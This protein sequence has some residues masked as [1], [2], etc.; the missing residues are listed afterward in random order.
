M[1][2][3]FKEVD[4][5]DPRRRFGNRG[6]D[7][8]AVFLMS[9]GFKIL[10]RNWSCR[11][12]EIDVIAE[13][14]GAVHFVEVKTRRSRMYGNPEDSITRTKLLHLRRTIEVYLQQARS[15]PRNYQA[16]A[17]AITA[18]PGQKPEFYYVEN[19]FG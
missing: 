3:D 5:L 19:I 4:S 11:L 15:A 1:A 14:N 9:R 7:L 8:A 13:K 10:A 18:I 2:S 16:D 6:E 17:L 12:G